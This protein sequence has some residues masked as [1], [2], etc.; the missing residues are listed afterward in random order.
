M[1]EI[2]LKVDTEIWLDWATANNINTSI[3]GF[4]KFQ[5][6]L[7]LSTGEKVKKDSSTNKRRGGNVSSDMKAT[8]PRG[9]SRINTFLGLL[10]AQY[11]TRDSRYYAELTSLADSTISNEAAVKF[12]AFVKLK[13]SVDVD[14]ILKNPKLIKDYTELSMKYAIIGALVDR[15]KTNKKTY[16]QPLSEV[17]VA[18]KDS[19]LPDYCVLLLR[20]MSNEGKQ[21]MFNNLIK[22]KSW[23]DLQD[24]FKK[25]LAK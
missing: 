7:L 23:N 13:D 18:F 12:A 24:V 9:W 14:A 16:L 3:Q 1:S 19:K 17:A 6:E 22:Q 4:I 5:P 10:D 8:T 11:V 15:Y 25:Y 20:M 21:F 2:E